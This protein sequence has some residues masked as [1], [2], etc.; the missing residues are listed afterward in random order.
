MLDLT[1][2][3]ELTRLAIVL[4]VIV[5]TLIYQNTGWTLGGVIVPG[6]FALFIPHPLQLVVTLLISFITYLFVEKFLLRRKIFYGRQLMEIEVLTGLALQALA[7]ALLT[8]LGHYTNLYP[9]F[10]GMGMVLPGIIAHDMARQGV[11]RT[12]FSSLLAAVTVYLLVNLIGSFEEILPRLNLVPA[13]LYHTQPEVYAFSP[14]YLPFAII[15]SVLL[16][17]LVLRRFNLHT[18]GFAATAYFALLLLRPLDLALLA[19]CSL[20]TYTLVAYGVPRVALV[21]GRAKLATMILVGVVISW[22]VELLLVYLSAGQ[23]N[24]WV[25]VKAM[26]PI[27]VALMAYEFDRQGLAKTALATAVSS[28]FTVTV[29][30]AFGWLAQ[31]ILPL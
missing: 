13:P 9:L 20:L 14:D 8:L 12:I 17:I 2:D 19:G 25:G 22:A 23:L 26:V 3:I 16:G 18:V 27:L 10:I 7:M 15:A 31:H 21:F 24:P 29:M 11:V 5:G 4:G 6:F 28:L 30:Q 1:H